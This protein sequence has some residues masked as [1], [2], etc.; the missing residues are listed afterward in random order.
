MSL[1]ITTQSYRND[2]ATEYGLLLEVDNQ[3]GEI[4]RT[5]RIDTPTLTEGFNERI[6]PGLRGIYIYKNE[7]YTATWN[8]IYVL[9]VQ[10]LEVKRS[11][12]HKWMSD[13]HGIFVDDDGVW[14]TSSY[15]DAMILYDFEGNPRATLWCPE[16]FLYDTRSVVDK[17][18]DWSQRGKEFRGFHDYHANNVE[19]H[20][21]YVYVT[22]RSNLNGRLARIHKDTFIAKGNVTDEDIVLFTKGL[23]GPHDGTWV[24]NHVYLTETMGS[25]LVC[26]NEKGKVEFRIKVKVDEKE[27]DPRK[28]SA[29]E[30]L[31]KQVA[32]LVKG[33]PNLD[34][35]THWTRGL[36]ITADHY[37]VGQSTW[38]GD[39]ESRARVVKID[40]K[41]R[42]IQGAFYLDIPDYPETRIYQVLD[43][44]TALA[45]ADHS[46][47]SSHSTV[48]S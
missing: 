6:K 16:T 38:A 45:K 14:V 44:E 23:L 5:K 11:F 24:D 29:L 28:L 1:L 40:R 32:S 35:T 33:R 26:L 31:R 12:T 37:Y 20:G 17:E 22:G 2:V 8:T 27:K 36:A 46:A 30:N 7:I 34:K 21:D 18:M 47:H 4:L 42:E 48:H 10:T 19:V 41:T 13:L 3:T 25:T 39:E 43:V 15:P 9:D